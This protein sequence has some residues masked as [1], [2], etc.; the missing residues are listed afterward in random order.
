[1][2]RLMQWREC[3]PPTNVAAGSN[4]VR[5][6]MRV[7]SEAPFDFV[8]DSRFASRVFILPFVTTMTLCSVKR[9]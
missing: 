5:F 7:E 6:H 8:V 2:T 4:P 3:L 1:M 9:A